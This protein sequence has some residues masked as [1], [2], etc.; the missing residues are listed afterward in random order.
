MTT[1]RKGPWTALETNT[2][3]DAAIIPMRLA[4]VRE[5]G[6]PLVASHWFIRREDTLW[7]AV[8]KDAAVA[9]V[10]SQNPRCGFEISA[11]APPY[12][13]VRGKALASL[14]P[15]GGPLLAEL[16]ERYLGSTET[17]LGRWLLSRADD[18]LAVQLT[19]ASLFTWDYRERMGS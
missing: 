16:L 15:G 9:N 1:Q 3:L 6:F 18:E 4:C 2:F 17:S 12:A 10:L 5:D 14:H 8:H 13:G 7:C 19:P 11:D